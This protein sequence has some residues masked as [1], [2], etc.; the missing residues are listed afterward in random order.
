MFE[1]KGIITLLKGDLNADELQMEIIDAGVEDFEETDEN[2]V[3]TTPVESFAA[4]QRKLEEM[5]IEAE[6]A[7]LQRIPVETKTLPVDDALKVLRLVELFEE[8]DDIQNVFHNL[9]VTEEIAEKMD[10]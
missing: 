2:F 10:S 7:E 4:V 5:G 9:E 8:D 3:I 1:R 6:N